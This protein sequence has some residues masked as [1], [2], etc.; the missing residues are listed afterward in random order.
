[1]IKDWVLVYPVLLFHT[2]NIWVEGH[3]FFWAWS[4]GNC[5]VRVRGNLRRNNLTP[6][7]GTR[8][9]LRRIQITIGHRHLSKCVRIV[10]MQFLWGQCRNAFHSG[11]SFCLKPDPK[12]CKLHGTS[13]T[14]PLEDQEFHMPFSFSDSHSY[15]ETTPK[16]FSQWHTKSIPAFNNTAQWHSDFQQ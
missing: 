14:W 15:P 5:V 8:R 12:R 3:P 7:H 2:V 10:F 6:P 16:T 13:S 4:R 9:N 11:L 1:M